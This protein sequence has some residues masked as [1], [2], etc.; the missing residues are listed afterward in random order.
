[1]LSSYTMENRPKR[2]ESGGEGRGRPTSRDSV[3]LGMGPKAG[4]L[5]PTLTPTP[6]FPGEHFHLYPFSL[7]FLMLAFPERKQRLS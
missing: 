5:A 4:V 6:G 2:E 1:M 3:G 7:G